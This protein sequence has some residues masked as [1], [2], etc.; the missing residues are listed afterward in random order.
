MRSVAAALSIVL[1]SASVWGAVSP[2]EEVRLI[3]KRL[4]PI[5]DEQWKTIAGERMS[6]TVEV[7]KGDTLYD[8][9]GRLFGDP[10]YWPKVWALNNERITN[11]HYI[12][13]GYQIAFLPGTGSELPGL[14]LNEDGKLVDAE[15]RPPVGDRPTS[16]SQEWKQL[17]K[18][19][20]EE[21]IYKPEKPTDI[22]SINRDEQQGRNGLEMIDLPAYISSDK[23]DP[24]GEL[25]GSTAHSSY[26]TVGDTVFVEGSGLQIGETYSLSPSP[27]TISASGFDGSGYSYLKRGVIVVTGMQDDLYVAT[28]QNADGIVDR[29]MEVYP[30]FKPVPVADP[31]PG[32]SGVEGVMGVDRDFTVYATAQHKQVFVDR[33]TESGVQPGMVF[34]SYQH[35]DPGTDSKITSSDM[36]VQADILILQTST[37]HSTGIV[38]R[39]FNPVSE[40]SRVVLLTDVS[41]L[42]P[43][44]KPAPVEAPPTAPVDTSLDSDLD[45]PAP[46]PVEQPD[47]LD[48][49]DQGGELTD[50][51]KK[52]L[53]QLEGWEQNPEGLTPAPVP[54]ESVPGSGTPSDVPPP[55]M[56]E[57]VPEA[58]PTAEPSSMDMELDAPSAE[59]APAPAPP[60]PM[61]SIPTA[62]TEPSAPSAPPSDPVPTDDASFDQMMNSI[63]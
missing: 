51:E 3:S 21:Y 2:Q 10:K 52:T 6:Q 62:P 48:Q 58:P 14:T 36:V 27:T 19:P 33:G 42:N 32:P 8:L 29:N 57:G 44:Y 9:S 1:V 5:S 40:G 56:P 25:T 23:I 20:W 16:R 15:G 49:L 30:L 60:A 63:E 54:S 31:I 39:S 53:K 50:D 59:V 12:K 26:L 24:V 13:P 11:P 28:I 22:F 41:D 7:A 35:I 61:D 45:A 47:Q 46:E 34:R 4:K 37:Q 55:M 43:N 18:Q 17:P 38:L